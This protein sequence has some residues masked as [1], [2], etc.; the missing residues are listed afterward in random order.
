MATRKMKPVKTVRIQGGAIDAA[1]A[2]RMAGTPHDGAVLTFTGTARD[3]TSGKKVLHLEYEAYEGMALREMEKIADEAIRRFSVSS[4]I[5]IH[6]TGRVMPGEPSV[7][8]AVSTPHR[9]EGFASL[10]YIID[11]IKKTVPIWKR[12]FYEDGSVWVAERP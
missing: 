5:I 9:D 6:R 12:E 3:R 8:I 11:T 10:R 1:E 4:C 7:V 2:M